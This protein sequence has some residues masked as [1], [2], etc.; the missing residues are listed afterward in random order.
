MIY[1]RQALLHERNGLI[2]DPWV[3]EEL[4]S[5]WSGVVV[6]LERQLKE[7]LGIGRNIR[8]NGG[9]RAHADLEY[10]VSARPG[11]EWTLHTLKIACI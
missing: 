5:G 1:V 6:K 10:T 3:L 7:A 9:L 8:G 4:S 11:H 2:C